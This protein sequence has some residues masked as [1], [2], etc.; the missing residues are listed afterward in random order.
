MKAV[1]L[2]LSDLSTTGGLYLTDVTGSSLHLVVAPSSVHN[3]HV[4]AEQ[5][6]LIFFN[7]IFTYIGV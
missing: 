6:L 1:T 3:L 2:T 7:L 5:T 4:T